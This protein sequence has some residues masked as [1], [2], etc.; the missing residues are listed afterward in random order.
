MLL[1]MQEMVLMEAF[2]LHWQRQLS[3]LD[4]RKIGDFPISVDGYPSLSLGSGE[5]VHLSCSF[6]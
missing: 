2:L 4:W 5:T 3:L 6:L 1:E